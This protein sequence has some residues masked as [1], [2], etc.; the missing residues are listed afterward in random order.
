MSTGKFIVFLLVPQPISGCRRVPSEDLPP[1]D[2]LPPNLGGSP[3]SA[4]ECGGRCRGNR[5]ITCRSRT[6]HTPPYSTSYS[7]MIKECHMVTLEQWKFA[8][9]CSAVG[10]ERGSQP[11]KDGRE[12]LA[13]NS[14]A[15]IILSVGLSSGFHLRFLVAPNPARPYFPC[16][17]ATLIR[18]L[19]KLDREKGLG[20]SDHRRLRT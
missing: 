16:R 19:Q 6:V 11:D 4:I 10:L 15:N 9:E 17:A 13:E 8:G 5:L 2:F 7:P 3:L 20:D 18:W 12:W 1:S 14:N